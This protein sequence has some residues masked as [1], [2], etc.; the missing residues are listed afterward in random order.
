MNSLDDFQFMEIIMVEKSYFEFLKRFLCFAITDFASTTNT[1]EPTGLSYILSP[2]GLPGGGGNT[3]E[4]KVERDVIICK[5]NHPSWS[6]R[7]VFRKLTHH[8]QRRREE[9]SRLHPSMQSTPT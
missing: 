3:V 5:K 9:Q 2:T 8:L 1:D 6:G 7:K 4:E